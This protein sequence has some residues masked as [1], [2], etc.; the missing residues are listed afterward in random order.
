MQRT[1]AELEEELRS[2]EALA[3]GD[4]AEAAHT[5]AM[6]EAQLEALQLE[7]DEKQRMLD[8]RDAE[9]RAAQDRCVSLFEELADITGLQTIADFT[10]YAVAHRDVIARFGRFPHRNAILGRES[11]P[12]ELQYLETH[13]GF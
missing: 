11:T 13:G 5:I 10:R 1:V 8:V 4:K 7:V 12:E 6:L 2:L 3:A 9:E